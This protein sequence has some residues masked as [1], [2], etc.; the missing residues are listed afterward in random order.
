[1]TSAGPDERLRSRPPASRCQ[2]SGPRRPLDPRE[3]QRAWRAAHPHYN[4]DYMRAWR[5][6][7]R[8]PGPPLTASAI[9]SADVRLDRLERALKAIPKLLTPEQR[10]R[11]NELLRR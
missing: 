9:R 5:A 1:M 3:Y 10:A 4:R 11:L 2:D 8:P 6:A 7:R